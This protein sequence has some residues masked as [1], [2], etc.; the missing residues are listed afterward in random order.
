MWDD[1]QEAIVTKTYHSREGLADFVRHA[2]PPGAEPLFSKPITF[3]QL[4]DDVH[5]EVAVLPNRGY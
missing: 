4:R 3:G 1:E 5:V 2:T